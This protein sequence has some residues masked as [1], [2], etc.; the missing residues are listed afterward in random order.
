MDH[1][2]TKKRELRRNVLDMLEASNVKDKMEKHDAEG[3]HDKKFMDLTITEKVFFC[4]DTPFLILTY[5]T[6]LPTTKDQFSKLR[7]L[8]W[9]IPGTSFFCW[10]VVN[11]MPNMNWLLI[12]GPIVVILMAAFVLFIP[13][14]SS[15]QP[16]YW[17]MLMITLIGCANSCTWMYLLIELLIDLLNTVGLA[18]NIESSYLGF[19]VIAI[20]NALPDALNTMHLAKA[21]QGIMAISGAYNGQ[22]F[23]LL[24]GFSI[25]TLKTHFQT[26]GVSRPFDLFNKERVANNFMGLLVIFT[27]LIVL[28]FSWIWAVKNKFLMSR[29]FARIMITIYIT[30]WGTATYF[31]F[32][33]N[34]FT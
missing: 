4:V 31:T 20:G 29:M 6:I 26:K 12:G 9:V 5:L 22:L 11:K 24:I 7:C 10:M 18:F 14:D 34:I 17:L 30:F 13:N 25:G 1:D 33:R 16:P 27:A 8:I 3:H 19:S 15:K 23:G 28:I 21:G 2:D 32:F